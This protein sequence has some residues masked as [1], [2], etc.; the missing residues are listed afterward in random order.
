MFLTIFVVQQGFAG[1]A[2]FEYFF[3]HHRT[4]DFRFAVDDDHLEGVEGGSCITVCVGCDHVDHLI[5]DLDLPVAEPVRAFDCPVNQ[6]GDITD[7]QGIEHKYLAAGKKRGVDLK[8]G[9]FRGGAD[10]NDGP[11]FHIGE[12]GILLGF[13]EAVNLI[14]EQDGL[15]SL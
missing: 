15:G 12:K 8:G 14:H 2:L 5:A 9:V 7:I 10:Q 11:P 3:G 4:A 13:V 1:D 6:I